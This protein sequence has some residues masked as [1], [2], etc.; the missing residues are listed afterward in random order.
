MARESNLLVLDEPTNDLDMET[1]DLLEACLDSYEG[2]VLLISHDRDFVSSLATRI[3]DMTPAGI[4]DFGLGSGSDTPI[5]ITAK[6]LD[7]VHKE[8]RARFQQNVRVIQDNVT[9]T[10]DMLD[11]AFARAASND[12][13]RLNQLAAGLEGSGGQ[14]TSVEATGRVVLSQGD[15]Q[16]QAA[17]AVFD[18]KA[19]TADLTGGVV[20]T[21]GRDRVTAKQAT[22]N[23]ANRAATLTGG[24]TITSPGNR[25]VV[26]DQVTMNEAEGTAQLSGGVRVAQGR[27]RLTGDRLQINQNTGE[28]TL[29]PANGG[30]RAGQVISALLHREDARA[31]KTA[32]GCNTPSIRQRTSKPSGVG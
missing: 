7:V 3:I 19:Q 23:T 22:F 16:V 8:N 18:A 10:S 21:R 2:T 12:K 26:A 9:I 27:N 13:E 20:M 24:V 11:V 30:P 5:T 15:D 29:L 32:S 14:L 25:T 1:L 6:R 31:G 17:K 4:V 28:M